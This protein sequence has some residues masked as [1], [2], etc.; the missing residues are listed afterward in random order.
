[1]PIILPLLPL[2]LLFAVIWA[3]IDLSSHWDSVENNT[4]WLIII[5]LGG[6]VGVLFY[7]FKVFQ[8]RNS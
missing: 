4:L 7:Y 8:P 3:L 5:F 2:I 6:F 1:M